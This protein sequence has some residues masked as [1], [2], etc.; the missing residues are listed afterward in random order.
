MD[1]SFTAKRCVSLSICF[2][3]VAVGGVAIGLSAWHGLYNTSGLDGERNYGD[4]S[5]LISIMHSGNCNHLNETLEPVDPITT[6]VIQGTQPPVVL[7]VDDDHHDDD[8][9]HHARNDCAYIIRGEFNLTLTIWLFVWG[10]GTVVAMTFACLG[11]IVKVETLPGKVLEGFA[12]VVAF[13]SW[14]PWAIVGLILLVRRWYDI[15]GVASDGW[16]YGWSIGA[17]TVCFIVWAGAAGLIT[18]GIGESDDVAAVLAR[19]LVETGQF[20]GVDEKEIRSRLVSYYES[21]T[22]ITGGYGTREA[23]ETVGL[24]DATVQFGGQRTYAKRK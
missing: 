15:P 3:F 17:L 16:V 1:Y 24:L 7:H 10:I 4:D 22:S 5:T 14:V 9:D 13:F 8:D 12:G 2:I 19:K 11:Y 23:A 21:M 18:L 20:D 6:T